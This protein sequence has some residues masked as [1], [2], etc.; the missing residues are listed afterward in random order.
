MKP[1][2]MSKYLKKLLAG[3]LITTNI[4]TGFPAYA[5][6]AD[7]FIEVEEQ[8][9]DQKEETPVATDE[10]TDTD[11]DPITDGD[12]ATDENAVTDEDAVVDEDAVTSEDTIADED[13]VASEDTIADEDIVTDEDTVMDENIVTDEDSTTDKDITVNEDTV[14]DE[15]A[16][17]DEDLEGTEETAAVLG[18]ETYTEEY[19]TEVLE[20]Q[21]EYVY[22]AQYGQDQTEDSKELQKL[23]DK[24]WDGSIPSGEQLVI[25]IPKGTYYLDGSLYIYDNTKLE[26]DAEAYMIRKDLSKYMLENAHRDLNK[27][28]CDPGYYGENCTH[29]GYSQTKN[30]SVSGG[31]WNGNVGNNTTEEQ[32]SL[33]M[34]VHAEDIVFENTVVTNGSGSHMMVLNGVGNTRIEN[35]TFKDFKYYTGTDKEYY[36]NSLPA[37]FSSLTEAQK[38]SLAEFKETLHIDAMNSIGTTMYPRDDTA[39][40]NIT[41]QGCTFEDVLAGVGAHQESIVN[42]HDVITI[43]ANT[44]TNVKGTAVNAFGM[45]NAV[46]EGNTVNGAYAF[47]QSKKGEFSLKGNKVSNISSAA[48]FAQDGCNV[49]LDNESYEIGTKVLRDNFAVDISGCVGVIKNNTVI[50]NGGRGGIGIKEGSKVTVEQTAVSTNRA[51]TY[52]I[53]I[54]SSDGTLTNNTVTGTKTDDYGIIVQNNTSQT[55]TIQNNG[56]AKAN[57]G[58][59]ILE[60]QGTIDVTGNTIS[61]MALYGIRLVNAR[62]LVANNTIE[63]VSGKENCAGIRVIVDA[64]NGTA[65]S[66]SLVIK[67]NKLNGIYRG[68]SVSKEK[69]VRIEGNTVTNCKDKGI[70]IN[71]T[72]NIDVIQNKAVGTET[73]EDIVFWS[74]TSGTCEKNTIT[75][76]IKNNIIDDTKKIKIGVNYE[77]NA[78]DVVGEWKKEGGKWYFYSQG[79]KLTGWRKINGN[80]YYLDPKQNGAM[81]T[82]W[83]VVD[84]LWYY[85][86]TAK[87]KEGIMATGWKYI[88]KKWYY[89]DP[90]KDGAMTTGW[91]YINGAWYYLDPSKGGAMATGWKKIGKAWYYL[92]GSKGGAM[93]TGWLKIGSSWYYLDASKGG[94]MTTGWKSIN[95]AWYY[96]DGSKGGAMATGWKEIGKKWY[97][98]NASKGGAMATG[99]L[100][101]GRTWY[102]LDSEKGGA[103]VTGWKYLKGSWYYFGASGDM[104]TGK[105]T[106]GGKTYTFSSDGVLK[107]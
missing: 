7:A 34:F 1:G 88:S 37:N 54:D 81:T 25:R 96:L 24:A 21:T 32:E 26:L 103:M 87:G 106:I 47:V 27:D 22:D 11:E 64:K 63:K 62:A 19:E 61:D 53:Y 58:I 12:V 92:N 17:A 94:A 99:W 28:F 14:T 16:V 69:N 45:T 9:V 57:T 73:E 44:F 95:G 80:C 55:V 3:I 78:A 41:V 56:V 2:H 84:G 52:G 76:S 48:V 20:A 66:S 86:D 13:D 46:I 43:K 33:I 107:Q 50:K 10:D 35:V 102:Y 68:I 49:T 67:E 91:K 79:K 100:K 42:K 82:D 74:C 60:S 29:G 15:N 65:P 18:T 51:D 85:L 71:E 31:V 4:A 77:E 93:A 40:S 72:E 8:K 38:A 104:V 6:E 59:E 39:C 105:K 90:A 101:L 5:A 83:K 98:L 36:G 89:F 70:L 23:L 97:F 30:I 75:S